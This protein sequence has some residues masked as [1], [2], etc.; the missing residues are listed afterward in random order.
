[1]LNR[2]KIVCLVV[3][4]IMIF[5]LIGCTQAPDSQTEESTDS[6]ESSDTQDS[7][8][9]EEPEAAAEPVELT[10]WEMFW[11]P[12]DTWT[13]AVENLVAKFND[14]HPNIKVEVQLIP[15]DNYYQQ[16]L[17][18]VTS[19]A[20]PDV[21]TGAFQQSIQYAAMDE[22]L[23][24]TSIVDEWKA[25]G[26][27]DDFIPG[28]IELHQYNG[29]QAGI[30]W[31]TDPRSITYRKD[32]FEQAGITKMPESWDEFLDVCRQIKEETGITPFAVA[33][34]DHM[35]NH[36]MLYFMF[37]NGIGMCDENGE[38]TFND[39]K[40]VETLQF[41]DTLYKEDLIPKGCASYKTSDLDQL[42]ITGKVA[43]VMKNVPRAVQTDE[44]V[45][46]QLSILKTF[47]AQAGGEGHAMTWINPIVAY[48]Q[49]EHPE[50]A[51]IFIKWWIENNLSL[52]TE[53]KGE[54]FPA[55]LS[56]MQDKYYTDDILSKE[57]VENVFPYSVAPVWPTPNIFPSFS[58]I[59]GENY[60]GKA[61]QE[62]LTG[63]DDFQTIVDNTNQMIKDAIAE[64]E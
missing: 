13:A 4:L 54:T 16:Y 63:N 27:Y 5:S 9:A 30:P 40:V 59:D 6:S 53:G 19:G 39:A 17:T 36:T 28:S 18:A 44:T 49:T 51:K 48:K 50:E 31:T 47:P 57:T 56:F 46:P 2:K 55:R 37:S 22:I 60:V 20:A 14:E 33:A 29:I 32:I 24:L 21:S 45:G 61:I 38:A 23:D 42:L 15:W 52:F 43:M 3:S 12:T 26:T 8:T 34:G 62:V 35:S 41:I 58:Q 11:G 10:F 7:E 25:D 1:M 64:A